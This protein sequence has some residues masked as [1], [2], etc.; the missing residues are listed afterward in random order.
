MFLTPG[1]GV[2]RTKLALV[3]VIPEGTG[4]DAAAACEAAPAEALAASVALVIL[5]PSGNPYTTPPYDITKS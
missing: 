3:E 1:V 5:N 4:V 2:V